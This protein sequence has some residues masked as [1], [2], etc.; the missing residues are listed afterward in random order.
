MTERSPRRAWIKWRS[1]LDLT[2]RQVQL[3]KG[4][5]RQ[6]TTTAYASTYGIYASGSS[7]T[8][9]RTPPHSSS[10]GP[11]GL[12]T[13]GARDMQQICESMQTRDTSMWLDM[14]GDAIT[15]CGAA[16]DFKGPVR[17]VSHP[18]TPTM[19]RT[20]DSAHNGRD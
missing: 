6:G 16:G 3:Y 4:L 5:S 20:A 15:V 1:T 18:P 7:Y 12:L 2:K 14:H 19:T 17:P 11:L 13:I 10:N 9:A 8:I